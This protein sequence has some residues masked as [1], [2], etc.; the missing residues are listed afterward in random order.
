MHRE[1]PFSNKLKKNKADKTSSRQ[2]QGVIEQQLIQQVGNN[3]TTEL[4][5]QFL[6]IQVAQ[7]TNIDSHVKFAETALANANANSIIQTLQPLAQLIG[8]DSEI[9]FKDFAY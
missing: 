1:Y 7:S 6:A 8:I 4:I 9:D 2:K 5:N 3:L